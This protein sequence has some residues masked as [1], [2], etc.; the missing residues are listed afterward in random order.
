MGY[1]ALTRGREA[2]YL[3]VAEE[4]DHVRAEFAPGDPFDLRSTAIATT[5][6]A[7]QT[8]AGQSMAIDSLPSRPNLEAEIAE[9]RRRIEQARNQLLRAKAE[10]ERLTA[11]GALW[12]P[13]RRRALT[14]AEAVE[15]QARSSLTDLEMRQSN[16]EARTRRPLPPDLSERAAARRT[17]QRKQQ[18]G[19]DLGR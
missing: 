17:R 9:I 10:R 13:A 8:S 6:R 3:Y 11:R 1:T 16:L 15:R 4:R 2:N 18:R 12:L 7:L 19:W 5:A 14:S